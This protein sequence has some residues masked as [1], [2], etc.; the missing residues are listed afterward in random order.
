MAIRLDAFSPRVG[1]Y[2]GKFFFELKDLGVCN[3]LSA[4]KISMYLRDSFIPPRKPL[5]PV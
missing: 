2:L 4:C 3:A 1:N 5:V